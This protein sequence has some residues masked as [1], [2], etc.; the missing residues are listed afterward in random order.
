ME[1]ADLLGDTI[2]IMKKGCLEVVGTPLHLKN[3]YGIGYSLTCCVDNNFNNDE[4]Y[5]FIL[6]NIPRTEKKR[7]RGNEQT[8]ILPY[9]SV[10][11][12]PTFF[13]KFD[14]NLKSLNIK[15]YGFSMTTLEEVFLRINE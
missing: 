6:E 5:K 1:E 10:D 12:F 8:Y 4:A 2:A 15:S 3:H 9:S 14:E 13:Q 11:L 7:L